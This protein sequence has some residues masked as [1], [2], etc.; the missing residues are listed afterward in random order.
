[1]SPGDTLPVEAPAGRDGWTDQKL[2]D[3]KTENTNAL[4]KS[5]LAIVFSVVAVVRKLRVLR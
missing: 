3:E 4:P 1:L 5:G 2:R